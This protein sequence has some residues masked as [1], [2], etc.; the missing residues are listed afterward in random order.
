MSSSSVSSS[1]SSASSAVSTSHQPHQDAL[2]WVPY[3]TALAQLILNQ[4]GQKEI[5]KL[6]SDPE[7]RPWVAH[8]I[9]IVSELVEVVHGVIDGYIARLAQQENRPTSYAEE[10][11]RGEVINRIILI[12]KL[13]VTID[14]IDS[15]KVLSL[16]KGVIKQIN[17]PKF[18][19]NQKPETV[20]ALYGI[21]LSSARNCGVRLFELL[22]KSKLRQWQDNDKFLFLIKWATSEK[23]FK[24]EVLNYALQAYLS[25]EA[26]P[27]H[28]FSAILEDHQ[29]INVA[30]TLQWI[31]RV[32]NLDLRRELKQTLFSLQNLVSRSNDL[33]DL[34]EIV[35]Q[36]TNEQID[37]LKNSKQNFDLEKQKHFVDLVK[38]L[39]EIDPMKV[40][41]VLKIILSY[42]DPPHQNRLNHHTR[43]QLIN[44]LLQLASELIARPL[45]VSDPSQ[46]SLILDTAKKQ[47]ELLKDESLQQDYLKSLQQ[48]YLAMCIFI[49]AN[50][51]PTQALKD[52]KQLPTDSVITQSLEK[53]ITERLQNHSTGTQPACPFS[54]KSL[55]TLGIKKTLGD[56][57]RALEHGQDSS[58]KTSAP[59]TLPRTVSSRPEA[60]YEQRLKQASAYLANNVRSWKTELVLIF[61]SIEHEDASHQESSLTQVTEFLEP[62]NADQQAAL[63]SELSSCSWKQAFLPSLYSYFENLIAKRAL[64]ERLLPYQKLMIWWES[65]IMDRKLFLEKFTLWRA[66]KQ[67]LRDHSEDTQEFTVLEQIL[68]Q[69]LNSRSQLDGVE[70]ALLLLEHAKAI[71]LDVEDVAKLIKQLVESIY[72]CCSSP[73]RG[74]LRHQEVNFEATAKKLKSFIEK[75]LPGVDADDTLSIYYYTHFNC[76]DE[77]E[78]A[79]KKLTDWIL[80]VRDIF[81]LRNLL[82]VIE[83]KKWS[84]EEY[85]RSYLRCLIGNVRTRL[86]ALKTENKLDF[87]RI[88]KQLLDTIRLEITFDPKAAQDYMLTILN[89]YQED[90]QKV[91][92]VA[93]MIA[94]ISKFKI[95]GKAIPNSDASS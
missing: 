15:E 77:L 29:A 63:I 49:E 84:T 56:W 95:I 52:L 6:I 23:D 45:I 87:G 1:Y 33:E 90:S 65:Q 70:Y 7:S 47:T 67:D 71:K 48:D 16:V 78:I 41:S 25:Q 54:L 5:R 69:I 79:T 10:A 42:C 12:V 68:K 32:P 21:V 2:E 8:R 73:W 81:T 91:E 28:F 40:W 38:I 57:M 76:F 39:F 37:Y 88:S 17:F 13:A 4:A 26:P 19:S 85:R 44:W 9:I 75:I 30:E 72:G 83:F 59:Q 80:Q 14:T 18:N 53:I 34:P 24:E 64:V 82:D 22:E 92:A 94:H 58:S 3:P 62:L 31:E 51:S 55:N 35:L 74:S 93:A 11:Q 46:V 20:K 43:T 50:W 27:T 36:Y 86:V 61:Q 89:N 60:W 66:L